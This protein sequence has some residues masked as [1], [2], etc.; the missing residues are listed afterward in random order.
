MPSEAW[1]R[2]KSRL[3]GEL[4][5][6]V[7]ASWFRGV[8]VDDITGGVIH[9]T[10]ATRFLRNWLRTHYYDTVL[11]QA[12]GD[13]FTDSPRGAGHQGDLVGEICFRHQSFSV[14]NSERAARMVTGS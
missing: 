13:G 10:V 6:D 2:I 12:Q 4:G 5:E 7:Y 8:E 14:S 3:R 1:T 11:R 9:L